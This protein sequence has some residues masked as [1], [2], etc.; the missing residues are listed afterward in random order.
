MAAPQGIIEFPGVESVISGTMTRSHGI[1]PSVCVVKI[2]PQKKPPKLIGTLK[3]TFGKVK[4][5][6]PDSLIDS[7]SIQTD[8][9]GM[10]ISLRIITRQWK[11]AFGDVS[12]NFNERLNDGSVKKSTEKEPQEIA[13]NF[14]IAM[15]EKRTDVTKLNNNARPR[16]M[17]I[18]ANPAK[19]LSSFANALGCRIITTL[20][21]EVKLVVPGVGKDLPDGDV[22]SEGMGIDP[23]NRPDIVRLVG[24]PTVFQSELVLEAVGEEN[25]DNHTLKPIDELSYTPIGGWGKESPQGFWGV[26]PGEPQATK[27][28]CRQLALKTVYRLYRIKEQVGGGWDFPG[29]NLEIKDR[30]QIVLLPSQIVKAKRTSK[31]DDDPILFRPAQIVGSYYPETWA[32]KN[33]G[34]NTLSDLQFS[35][36]AEPKRQLVEFPKP[37]YMYTSVLDDP[38]QPAGSRHIEYA[39]AEIRLVTSYYVKDA[40]TNQVIRAEK[41]VR[42][43]KG[44]TQGEPLVFPIVREDVYET[45]IAQFKGVTQLQAN[46]L[47]GT[48]EL[49]TVEIKHKKTIRNGNEFN[50]NADYYL[51]PVIKS[52]ENLVTSTRQYAGIRDDIDL[53]GAISQITY[54]I[55]SSGAVTTVSR[56]SEHDY[57]VP[58]LAERMAAESGQ[59]V[60]KSSVRPLPYAKFQF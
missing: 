29:L 44:V 3:F 19:E 35:L 9:G 52:F 47:T 22:M 10:I 37:V 55:G 54:D 30:K 36:D 39:P 16:V 11:W 56:N 17:C 23:A 40:D 12:S 46:P 21:N 42:I 32:L 33:T 18:A 13:K 26:A 58:P 6:F 24:G 38:L 50:D 27:E 59:F 14:L 48:E 49:M 20:K 34:L 4:L 7:A 41:D 25:D 8:S 31:T 51:K 45:N 28:T 53:D 57:D 1:S 2:A 60:D 43:S 5:E 15:G